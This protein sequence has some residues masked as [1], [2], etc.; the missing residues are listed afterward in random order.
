MHSTR[1]IDTG[2]FRE[3]VRYPRSTTSRNS[4]SRYDRAPVLYFNE[5]NNNGTE[6][7]ELISTN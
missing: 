1:G 7:L 5:A 3:I 4:P 2:Q 6:T